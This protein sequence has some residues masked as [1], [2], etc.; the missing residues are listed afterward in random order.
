MRRSWMNFDTQRAARLALIGLAAASLAAC[1]SRPKP[2]PVA[3]QQPAP[4]AQ[5][6]EPAKPYTPPPAPAQ[7]IGPIP[8]SA[9]DFVVNIGERI[10]FDTDEY[11][12]R[13]DAQPLLAGQAQ[14]LNRYPSVKVRIEGN[15]DERG[16]REYNLALGARRANAVRDFLVAQGVAA[17]RIE[18]L[19]YGKERPIDAGTTEEAWAK[20]RNART[21]LTDGAR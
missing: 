16:T 17:A 12:V 2:E 9:Q 20:N 5:P 11:V 4:V 7:P 14:W 3:P 10:Y 1:A 19:S 18:T 21:A 6:A 8:G 13:A 15:A